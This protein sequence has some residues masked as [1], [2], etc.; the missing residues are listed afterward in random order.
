MRAF[1]KY[2][3]DNAPSKKCKTHKRIGSDTVN[4]PNKQNKTSTWL[5]KRPS[6]LSVKQE[7]ALQGARVIS[8]QISNKSTTPTKNVRLTNSENPHNTSTVPE[9]DKTPSLNSPMSEKFANSSLTKVSNFCNDESVP[10]VAMNPSQ[11]I[12]GRQRSSTH[13]GTSNVS[14]ISRARSSSLKPTSTRGPNAE[15]IVKHSNSVSGSSAALRKLKHYQRA[16]EAYRRSAITA[17]D[18]SEASSY[19]NSLPLRGARKS[20]FERDSIFELW[21]SRF[22][23]SSPESDDK[24]SESDRSNDQCSSSSGTSASNEDI[25]SIRRWPFVPMSGDVRSKFGDEN[26][27]SLDYRSVLRHGSLKRTESSRAKLSLVKS[28][29][30]HQC[31]DPEVVTDIDAIAGFGMPDKEL[32]DGA[33]VNSPSKVSTVSDEDKSEAE[34]IVWSGYEKYLRTKQGTKQL[35]RTSFKMRLAVMEKKG[36]DSKSFEA[37]ENDL[38]PTSTLKSTKDEE[39]PYVNL[40][41]NQIIRKR[42]LSRSNSTRTDSLKAAQILQAV[43]ALSKSHTIASSSRLSRLL[44]SKSQKL[45]PV[46]SPSLTR[47]ERSASVKENRDLNKPAEKMSKS[48]NQ[49]IATTAVNSKFPFYSPS[50]LNRSATISVSNKYSRSLP[51]R[52]CK[53]MTSTVA[54]STEPWSCQST[55]QS[56]NK[57]LNLKNYESVVP[58]ATSNIYDVPRSCRLLKNNSALSSQLYEPAYDPS[59]KCHNPTKVPAAKSS[60]LQFARAIAEGRLGSKLRDFAPG[61]YPSLSRDCNSDEE[62]YVSFDSYYKQKQPKKT[63]LSSRKLKSR[64]VVDISSTKLSFKNDFSSTNLDHTAKSGIS[65]SSDELNDKKNLPLTYVKRTE[66]GATSSDHSKTTGSNFFANRSVSALDIFNSHTN[67][68]TSPTPPTRLQKAFLSKD[69]RRFASGDLFYG[70]VKRQSKKV[71]PLTLEVSVPLTDLM[72]DPQ[73]TYNLTL[74]DD[75]TDVGKKD[76][77]LRRITTFINNESIQNVDTLRQVFEQKVKKNEEKRATLKLL[78]NVSR[79]LK[80]HKIATKAGNN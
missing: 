22:N 66:T 55:N 40:R 54:D 80:L 2:D 5:R 50:T 68:L 24:L 20:V 32:N 77:T 59:V 19:T 18:H 36:I 15:N 25:S 7:T 6:R 44:K 76:E 11:S 71:K 56:N 48:S 13:S 65:K 41:D 30:Y 21:G 28:D 57:A 70:V 8:R 46:P 37:M 35:P 27:L 9:S 14:P 78:T 49:P 52:K 60:A 26:S 62:D 29:P 51:R 17:A 1:V 43:G 74:T 3:D 34:K 12:Q 42:N 10:S 45:S 47:P 31:T 61:K 53:H 4:F 38:S 79:V 23:Y 69:K 75:A 73:A 67:R 39:S 58:T 72:N 64:S 33:N 63:S 16:M